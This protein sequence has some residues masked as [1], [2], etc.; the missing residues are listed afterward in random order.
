MAA[1]IAGFPPKSFRHP[2]LQL[3]LSRLGILT[4]DAVCAGNNSGL[5]FQ[6]RDFRLTVLRRS[7]A[8]FFTVQCGAS[9]PTKAPRLHEYDSRTASIM[10][11]PSGEPAVG[12]VIENGP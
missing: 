5:L 4:P 6:L 8:A 3:E 10:L 1:G 7:S 9:R 11:S 2:T 12:R